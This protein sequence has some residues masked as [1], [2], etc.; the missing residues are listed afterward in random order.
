[1][2][3]QDD[4]L[5]EID[6]AKPIGGN[7]APRL[8]V[9]RHKVALKKIQL[10]KPERA[11]GQPRI[12]AEFIV[13][14]SSGSTPHVAGETRGWPWFIGLNGDAG[15]YQKARMGEFTTAVKTSLG[16]PRPGKEV[17]ADLLSP[18]QKGKGLV[19]VCDVT[20]AMKDGKPVLS[21]KG[22]VVNNIS[23]TP[24]AQTIEAVV[25]TRRQIEAREAAQATGAQPVAA[26]VAQ[27]PPPAAPP[28]PPA[29]PAAAPATGGGMGALDKV[30]G[31]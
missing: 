23:W 4:L 29:Q 24:V 12:E 25:A 20:P 1:M 16:D 21:K 31:F 26:P 18:Q 19:L 17:N 28:T 11:G 15:Q 9:G 3:Y 10:K 6:E 22:E 7:Y 2:S 13:I 14:E 8:A 27:T 30:L 5:N